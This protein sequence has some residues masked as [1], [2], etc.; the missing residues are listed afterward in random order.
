[1]HEK[2]LIIEDD[3]DIREGVVTLLTEE[4]FTVFSAAAGKQ[5]IAEAVTHI[6]D[7]IICDILMR[8]MDG[9][10]VLEELSKQKE[11]RAIPFIYLTAKVERADIRR[12]MELGADDYLFKP[13]KPEE[14]L[15]AISTCL[16][17][18][19]LLK[20]EYIKT[21]KPVE[22]ESDHERIFLNLGNKSCFVAL[23]DIVYI[24]AE[25]Q[26]TSIAMSDGRNL[27]MRKPIA[28]WEKT[29]P[30]IK[31]VK[32][33]RSTIINLNY[34]VKMG[35]SHNSSFV[36]YLKNIADPFIISRRYSAELRKRKFN[37]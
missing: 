4:G 14:L 8:G 12:G 10:E 29:L 25:N 6:P 37:K 24:S 5:G 33:H 28:F 26:Y 3:Q 23:D 19:S 2:I 17:K 15:T 13:F 36:I 34:I 9:Y 35:K 31:F 32:I 16:Q 7:L 18:R 11:T 22:S 21:A 30:E 20:A 1:M 27:L